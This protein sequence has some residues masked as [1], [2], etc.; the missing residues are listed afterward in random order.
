MSKHLPSCRDGAAHAHSRSDVTLAAPR[1]RMIR[2]A[3][4]ALTLVI[5]QLAVTCV[6]GVARS[7]DEG[8]ATSS[9]A[10]P[11]PPHTQA[12]D[13]PARPAASGSHRT[14][15]PCQAERSATGNAQVNCMAEDRP[16]TRDFELDQNES[17]TVVVGD[18]VVVA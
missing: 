5:P 13:A 18:K 11:A 4:I 12:D 10:F 8:H 16:L 1:G 7:P 14:G 15:A 3:V 9:L 17:T 6:A 2:S